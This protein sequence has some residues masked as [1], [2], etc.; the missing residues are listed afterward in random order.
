M[1]NRFVML[2][3]DFWNDKINDK[4]DENE[5]I[6]KSYFDVKHDKR[7]NVVNVF[8]F[9]I[10]ST[11]DIDF[12]DVVICEINFENFTIDVWNDEVDEKK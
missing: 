12:F 8:D 11:H 5:K 10:I 9:E 4:C 6:K 1:K 2:L 7:E 3:I